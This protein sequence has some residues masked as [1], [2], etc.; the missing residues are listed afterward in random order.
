VGV[1]GCGRGGVGQR[2]GCRRVGVEDELLD[3]HNLLA[4]AELLQLAEKGLDLVDQS[5]TLCV[6]QLTQD[7][8]CE[9]LADC[10]QNCGV[11]RCTYG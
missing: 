10:H 9:G 5:F 2:A 11:E 3:G 1:R 6:L 8:L 7:F 4:V